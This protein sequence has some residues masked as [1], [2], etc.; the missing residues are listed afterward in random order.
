MPENLEERNARG[1]V[2]W[3]YEEESGCYHIYAHDGAFDGDIALHLELPE[4]PENTED[5][6][7]IVEAL[8]KM[9]LRS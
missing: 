8:N 9:A 5:I 2:A 3:D 6:K 4:T 7:I 1:S